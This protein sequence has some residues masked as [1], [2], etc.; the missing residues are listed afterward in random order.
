MTTSK[1]RKIFCNFFRI[2]DDV[3]FALSHFRPALAG[4]AT[5][6]IYIGLL[7]FGSKRRKR[8][9][10]SRCRVFSFVKYHDLKKQIIN[11]KKYHKT[12][13]LTSYI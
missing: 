11:C 2:L 6:T 8:R 13:L 1:M 7:K 10:K 12:T 5:T 3:I 9:V 4:L